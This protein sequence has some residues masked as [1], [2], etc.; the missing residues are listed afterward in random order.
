MEQLDFNQSG[1][2]N[3]IGFKSRVSEMLNRKRKLN[4]DKIR[5]LLSILNIPADV[6]IQAY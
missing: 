6:L 5:N 3:I 4:L 2:A 1:L